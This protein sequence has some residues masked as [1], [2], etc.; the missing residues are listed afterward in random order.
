MLPWSSTVLHS[1]PALAY[2]WALG[3]VVAVG[4][5]AWRMDKMVKPSALVR[6]IVA[7]LVGVL[8]VYSMLFIT[9]DLENARYLYLPAVFWVIAV[10]GFATAPAAS[11]IRPA[12]RVG[13]GLALAAGTIGVQWHLA[14][15]REAARLR[16]RVLTAAQ[17]AIDTA[18]CS[19]ASL[20]GAPDSV[21]GAYVFRNGL[22][23]AMAARIAST[24]RSASHPLRADTRSFARGPGDCLFVWNGS[25]FQIASNGSGHVQA[26][27]RRDAGLDRGLK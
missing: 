2:L 3:V 10:V 4:T 9:A 1:W 14:T 27:F 18:S 13:L 22:G 5:Y 16:D 21:R 23:E 20:A 12:V 6:C 8:P 24:P 11:R 7:V 19:T 15:W 26:T 25:A 17:A